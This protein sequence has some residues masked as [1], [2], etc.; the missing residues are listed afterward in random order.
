MH[1][2]SVADDAHRQLMQAAQANDGAA[3]KMLLADVAPLLRRYVHRQHGE[4][5]APE[6][7]DVV[8]DTLLSLHLARRTYDPARPFRP[9]LYAIARHRM[10]DTAR[11]LARRT[12]LE[13]TVEQLP[14]LPGPADSRNDGEIGADVAMLQRAIDRL[15]APQRMAIRLMKLNG[16]SLKEAS[17]FTGASVAALKVTV[18]RAMKALRHALNREVL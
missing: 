3:Y 13:S 9:W 11:R 1:G 16:Y 8:Q 6:I 4:W 18:H 2:F 10:A 15:S 7:E 5:T 14:D 17:A 12:G